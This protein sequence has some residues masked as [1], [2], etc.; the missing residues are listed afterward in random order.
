MKFKDRTINA[1][2]DMV[3]GNT[4]AGK[5]VIFLTAAVAT[6]RVFFGSATPTMYTMDQRAIH[7]SV[8]R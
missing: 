8:V 6:L 5:E 2:A 7:G 3:C 4:D 1:L